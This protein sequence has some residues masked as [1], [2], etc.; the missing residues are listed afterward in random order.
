MYVFFQLSGKDFIDTG[1]PAV[2][3]INTHIKYTFVDN[4]FL[5][6]RFFDFGQPIQLH[7]G[8]GMTGAQ[9]IHRAGNAFLVADERRPQ[10]A[11]PDIAY[12][13]G[14]NVL[15]LPLAPCRIKPLFGKVMAVKL[16]F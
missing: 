5:Q 9:F 1:K 13:I 7:F 16:Q 14:G 2:R 3:L 10:C 15:V 4:T 11:L 6:Q 12:D 8:K